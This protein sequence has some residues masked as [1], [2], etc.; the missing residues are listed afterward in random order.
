[1]SLSNLVAHYYYLGNHLKPAVLLGDRL[2]RPLE[3]GEVVSVLRV[4]QDG[5]GEGNSL[6]LKK[7]GNVLYFR[8]KKHLRT[9]SELSGPRLLS[10]TCLRWLMLNTPRRSGIS[11][12]RLLN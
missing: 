5:M 8:K 2:Q 4:G 3:G 10:S 6:Q 1:M 7:I 12:R 11:R 9:C